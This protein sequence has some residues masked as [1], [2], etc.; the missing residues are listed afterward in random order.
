VWNV[1]GEARGP[2]VK[3]ACKDIGRKKRNISLMIS[4]FKNLA[5]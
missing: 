5:K 3:Y 1:G 4:M 2:F